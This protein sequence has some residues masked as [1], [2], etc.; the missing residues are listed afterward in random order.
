MT[1]PIINAPEYKLNI[2]STD[3]VIRYRPFLVKEEKLLLIAQETGTD[4]A[5]YE[6]IRNI[7]KSCCLDPVDIN[8]LPLFDM[9][10]IFL[11]IR[12][13]SVGETVKIKVKCP[14]DEKTEVEVEVDLTTIKVEMD[15]THDA[16]LQLTDDIGVLMMYPSFE[17]VSKQQNVKEGQETQQLFHMI[18]SCMY[19]IWQGEETFD[20]MDYTEKDRLAFL[21]SL[22]HTQFEKLQVFFETMPT[23]KHDVDV[24]N[25]KTNV[26]SKITLQGI[27]AFF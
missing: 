14:D 3:E 23:L 16:R 22:S 12:A 17:T 19:Q 24:T 20:A 25:P 6:A 15:E 8:K 7:I 9:E 13:K 4:K 1:L 18:S 10:Y 5:T 11:N 27:N 26:T 21:E 2:P